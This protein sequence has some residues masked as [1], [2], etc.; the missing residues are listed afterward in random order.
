MVELSYA[1]SY[2]FQ[3]KKVLN[4]LACV[5]VKAQDQIEKPK[6]TRLEWKTFLQKPFIIPGRS[7]MVGRQK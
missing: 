5:S 3:M 1:I 7:K 2:H 6:K 4:P